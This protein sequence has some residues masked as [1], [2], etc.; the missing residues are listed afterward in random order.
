MIE[1]ENHPQMKIAGQALM[2]RLDTLIRKKRFKFD[3]STMQDM[4]EL[5]DD[6]IKMAR[7]K[8]GVAFPKLTALVIPRTGRIAL[9][10]ADTEKQGVKNM[11][12]RLVYDGATPQEVAVAIR[13]AFPQYRD[14]AEETQET[15]ALPH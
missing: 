15:I 8:W 7:W 1:D 4:G 13:L 10:R 9:C 5:I 12:V 2:K 14:L 3:A 6:H 11:A